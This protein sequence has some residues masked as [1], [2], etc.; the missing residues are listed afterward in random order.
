VPPE[1]LP[2]VSWSRQTEI[3]PRVRGF[4]LQFH[5]ADVKQEKTGLALELTTKGAKY[6]WKV[7][8]RSGT[9]E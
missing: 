8:D 6:Y 1:T 5:E 3:D 9:D 7:G 2:P 4:T